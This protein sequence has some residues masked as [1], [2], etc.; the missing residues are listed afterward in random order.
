LGQG[1][2]RNVQSI[3]LAFV[4]EKQQGCYWSEIDW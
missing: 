3:V 4:W 2:E 1:V